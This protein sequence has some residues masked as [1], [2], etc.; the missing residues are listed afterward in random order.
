MTTW[1]EL[2]HYPVAPWHVSCFTSRSIARKPAS[3]ARNSPLPIRRQMSSARFAMSGIVQ[4]KRRRFLQRAFL[5]DE[6][7]LVERKQHL[8]RAGE[9][10]IGAARDMGLLGAGRGEFAVLDRQTGFPSRTCG[11]ARREGRAGRVRWRP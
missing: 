2:T 5:V 10:P 3:A 1:V 4:R 6:I 8:R 7:A 9:R 11:S